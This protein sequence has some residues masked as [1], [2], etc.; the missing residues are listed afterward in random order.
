[1][2]E[3]TNSTSQVTGSS[4]GV[5]EP[6]IPPAV[7]PPQPSL[8]DDDDEDEPKTKG[9][10]KITDKNSPFWDRVYDV[11]EEDE[12]HVVALIKIGREKLFHLFTKG[13]TTPLENTAQVSTVEAEAAKQAS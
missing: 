1:M 10:V 11:L 13:Q 6:I 2:S 12:E 5:A 9:Q 8:D 4:S 7:I 3:T